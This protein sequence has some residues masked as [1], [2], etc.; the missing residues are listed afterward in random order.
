MTNVITLFGANGQPVLTSEAPAYGET[1]SPVSPVYAEYPHAR[2]SNKYQQAKTIEV[3]N[4]LTNNGWQITK[5][6]TARVRDPERQGFQKHFVHLRPEGDKAKLKVGDTE[7]RVIISNSH[8]GT[9]AFRMD[10]GLYRLVC[11]NGM[12]VSAGGFEHIALRHNMQEIEQEAIDGALRIAAMAPRINDVIGKMQDTTLT[13]DVQMMFASEAL[14]LVWSDTS[15]LNPA[16]F[17]QIRRTADKGD[18]LWL[19]FNRLQE[20]LVRGGLSVAGSNRHTRGINSPIKD[21]KVNRDL[22]ELAVKYAA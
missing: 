21:Y 22:F 20:N 9:S 13:N 8:D 11:S 1:P 18:N 12:V 15:K 6:T 2:V 10:A 14:K 7:L 4:A 19:V 3:V 5:T 17:L 16:E